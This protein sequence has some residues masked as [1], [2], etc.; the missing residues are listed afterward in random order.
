MRGWEGVWNHGRIIPSLATRKEFGSAHG[1]FGSW[2][3]GSGCSWK[4]I[5]I[6][7]KICKV[8]S[9]PDESKKRK[10]CYWCH[11]ITSISGW[12]GMA[13]K[14]LA[15]AL[16]IWSC[17]K[18]TVESSNARTW[19]WRGSGWMKKLFLT[20]RKVQL[21][22]NGHANQ[23]GKIETGIPQGSTVSPVFFFGSTSVGSL[24]KFKEI[25]YSTVIIICRW[26]GVY[27]NRPVSQI[28]CK[29]L[30]KSQSGC[31]KIGWGKCSYVRHR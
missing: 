26:F 27:C 1:D 6:L 22:I 3:T 9:R 19:N 4:I 31:I 11:C 18:K 17:G 13:E 28:N 14:Q 29:Y 2:R 5:T 20:N 25:I 21:I 12:I 23:E 16:F 7:L 24:L 8:T 30:G 10:V 15:A